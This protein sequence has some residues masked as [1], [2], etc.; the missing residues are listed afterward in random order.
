[1]I[2][3]LFDNIKYTMSNITFTE[4]TALIDAM[5]VAYVHRHLDEDYVYESQPTK[6]N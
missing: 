6:K 4:E 5:N 3:L 2:V 1:M